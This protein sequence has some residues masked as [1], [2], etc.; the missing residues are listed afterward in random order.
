MKNR[1]AQFDC[2]GGNCADEHSSDM[3][4]CHPLQVDVYATDA[5]QLQH[6]QDT[7]RWQ[8]AE[9]SGYD[10]SHGLGQ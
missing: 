9:P 2:P 7:G 10:G 6:A 3:A 8:P 5:A 4:Q 1:P